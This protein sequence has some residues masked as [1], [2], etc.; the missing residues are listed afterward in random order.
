MKKKRERKRRNRRRRITRHRSRY[1]DSFDT[2]VQRRWCGEIILYIGTV[3]III[4][5]AAAMIL[6][7]IGT[8]QSISHDDK[9]LYTTYIPLGRDKFG[10]KTAWIGIAWVWPLP[11]TST[12]STYY[13]CTTHIPRNSANC[14]HLIIIPIWV[15]IC[16]DWLYSYL[17]IRHDRKKTSKAW[18]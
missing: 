6:I 13:L 18:N 1:R 10:S 17:I 9:R 12:C 7:K 15:I 5:S 3:K 14:I 2:M 8:S 16:L 4:L 11:L